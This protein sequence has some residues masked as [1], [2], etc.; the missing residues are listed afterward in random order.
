MPDVLIK[1][2]KELGIATMALTDTHRLSGI[3]TFL[4]AAQQ[5]GVKAIVGAEIILEDFG[6]LILLVPSTLAYGALTQLLTTTSLTTPRKEPVVSWKALE[7]W[8]GSLVAIVGSRRSVI[9]QWWYRGQPSEIE[10]VLTRLQAIFLSNQL[11]LEISANFLPG[12]RAW[13]RVLSDLGDYLH[14][15]LVA[16]N[17][18]YYAKKSQVGIAD[19]L[20]CIRL[21]QAIE[22]VGP[23]RFLNAEN[24]I[25]SWDTMTHDLSQWPQALK[26]T[27]YLAD[28][29]ETPALLGQHYQPLF[30][31]PQGTDRD[32]YLEQLV[33]EGAR[34]RYGLQLEVVWPRI[35]KELG[36]I[37]HLRFSDYF[38]V[39]HDVAQYARRQGIRFAGRGSAADSVVAYCL[40]ITD[41]DAH[42][43]KLLFERFMSIERQEPPDIDID[44]DA[45]RRDEVMHYVYQRYG[46]DHV[47]RVA[48]YQT[49]R[50]RSAVRDVGKVMGFPRA[51][52]DALAKALP[53]YPI[54]E[55]LEKWDEIPELRPFPQ[56]HR[57]RQVLQW[58]EQFIGLPRHMGTHVGGLVI[59]QQ[60][61]SLVGPRELSPKGTEIISFDK[62]DIETLGLLKLDLLSL[63]TFTAIDGAV[64][65]IQQTHA[66]F[67]YEDI[68][69]ENPETYAQ[70]QS[71]ESIGVFQLESPAQRALARRLQPDRWEDIVASLALIRPGPIKGNMVDP[72]IARRK[73]LEPVTY[74]HPDLEPILSKTYGVILFQ[75]QVIE[76]ASVLAGFTPGEADLL[77]RVMSHS[78]DAQTMHDIGT[79]FIKK[80]VIRQVDPRVA[81]E[82]FQQIVGYA[83]YGFNEAHAAAFSET[84]YRTAYLLRHHP[85]SYVM[86]L[87]NAQPMGYYP[88]DVLLVEAR[89]RG[90][91]VA[92]IDINESAY[93]VTRI[94]DEQL[95]LGFQFI[96]GIGKEGVHRI[97]AQR[98]IT[99]P[100]ELLDSGAV[101][102]DQMEKLI[103]IGAF[104]QISLDRGGLLED[105]R[106]SNRLGIRHQGTSWNEGDT[107]YWDYQHLGFGQQKHWMEPWRT[108]AEHEGFLSVARF[109]GL[110]KGRSA[111][112]VGTVIRPHRPPTR[113]G[114]V[115]VFF[116]LLDETGLLEIHLSEQGYQKF[117]HLL[118]GERAF[119]LAVAGRRTTEGMEAVALT[120]W[121]PRS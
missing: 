7:Q 112:V 40:G 3:P 97:I 72:F 46:S 119:M 71:G 29:L 121:P 56:S 109:T 105:V 13:H 62:R 101:N 15:P 23:R 60:P 64:A 53:E 117:G 52:I 75:E 9:G 81:E 4:Q 47:A 25:K 14:I 26:N 17:A 66:S 5:Q 28:S 54:H 24:Y 118:F 87:L 69:L 63:K 111:R 2:A 76:I 83:S 32:G 59:S 108:M 21:G 61:L 80:A 30:S 84:A 116:S 88:I 31:L 110:P 49:Y 102:R 44:F 103:A 107:L 58:A 38:L 55:I 93:L 82:V 67:S 77:R 12:D 18:V 106:G 10:H 89:R 50:A 1:E 115:V 11:Y 57:V 19:I 86:G 95:R 27:E 51:D 104:D 68:P 91:R 33:K 90:I 113:S 22:E 100:F 94:S 85:V 70:L 65:D 48:T 35:V 34:R 36:V 114:R 6:P 39:V 92:P 98:P 78:R 20:A 96:R 16:T 41:V 79:Q 99:H 8:G 43:R 42:A 45:T 73:G 74:L 120:E 37:R